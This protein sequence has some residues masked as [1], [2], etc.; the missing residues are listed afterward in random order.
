[1]LKFLELSHSIK[2][3]VHPS[4]AD[5]FGF[6]IP[7]VFEYHNYEALEYELKL[8]CKMYPKITYLYSIGQSVE[9]RELYVLTISD[10]P[11]IHEPG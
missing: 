2:K 11:K 6:L 7:P 9:G 3:V 1:M 10:Q 4:S 8:L 5:L